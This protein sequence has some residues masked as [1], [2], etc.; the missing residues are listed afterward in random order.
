MPD[1]P[2]K[3]P[4]LKYLKPIGGFHGVSVIFPTLKDI[5]DYEEKK[6]KIIQGYPRFVTHPLVKKLEEKFEKSFKANGVLCCHSY[7][8]AIFLITDY[9]FRKGTKM[10]L[11]KG[12]PTKIFNLLDRKFKNLAE[13]SS[14]SHA[15]IVICNIDELKTNFDLKDKV[16]IGLVKDN[17]YIPKMSKLNFDILILNNKD[18]DAGIIIFYNTLHSE[19]NILRRHCGFIVSSRKLVRKENITTKKIDFY[20]EKL[21]KHL[22]SLE[23]ANSNQC[24]L[25]PSGMAAVFIAIFSII[26]SKKPKI[27]VLG[28]L[29]VDTIRILEKWFKKY[30]LHEPIFI[31]ENFLK[32]LKNHID[33]DT[34]G[35]IFEIPSN[36][37]IQLVNVEKII[38]LTH[39]KNAKVIVDNTIATPYNF[40]PFNYN[41]DLIVHS[42]TKFLNGKNNHIG[43]VLLAKNKDDIKNIKKINEL[44]DLNMCVGDMIVL[45]RNLKNFEAR[46]EKIN[47]NS[48]I[49]ANYLSK[50]KSVERVYY[51]TLKSDPNNLLM[52]KY[53][54]GASGLISFT[55][56]NSSFENAEKFYNN[57]HL[58]FLKGPSLGSEKT[59]LCP[60]VILAHFNDTKQELRK[61][62][63]DF[64]LMRMSVGTEPVDKILRSLKHGL[65]FIT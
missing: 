54:K 35:I 19:L 9:Y 58:P 8:S 27:I 43:G 48:E 44:V 3:I 64:Y 52:R 36:P 32:E 62:G 45:N 5:F 33:E 37:L 4:N 46:M 59:L 47:K 28:S 53:L 15:N 38:S 7:A 16:L 34:A 40:N 49:I 65:S 50:H 25:Y 22:S 30:D 10:Y 61:L 21:K 14:L 56:K 63:L 31:R 60:Y 39:L 11:S 24:F 18:N 29:Y 17:S 6:I 42:T 1:N 26:S 55:L 12:L 2:K 20:S 57:L 51:P 23:I 13:K 41:A